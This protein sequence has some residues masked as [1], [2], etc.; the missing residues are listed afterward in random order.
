MRTC[1]VSAITAL[2]FQV[3]A[4]AQEKVIAVTLMV[5]K[6]ITGPTPV[7][8]PLSLTPEQAKGARGGF[9]VAGDL[10]GQFVMPGL[11]TEHIKPAN[12]KDIRRDLHFI[13]DKKA[14]AG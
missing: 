11:L 6:D 8:V 12:P 7:C 14:A 13:L 4:Q 3:A 5:E 10:P 1:I 9:F 2:L